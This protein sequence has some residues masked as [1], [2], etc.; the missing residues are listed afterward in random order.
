ML[1]RKGSFTAVAEDFGISVPSVWQQIRA[2]EDA[3]DTSLVRQVGKTTKL[4]EHGEQLVQ[5]AQPLVD[6]FEQIHELFADRIEKLPRRLTVATTASLLLHELQRP[7]AVVRERH[8]DIELTFID[9]PSAIALKHLENGDADIA[10]IGRLAN[11]PAPEPLE[12][13]PLTSYPFMLVCP[14]GHPLAKARSVR[15]ADIIRHPLVLPGEGSNSRRHV[16]QVFDAAGVWRK[17]RIALTA[18]SFDILAGYVRTGFGI[19]VTSVSPI[20]LR[21]AAA[22]HPGYQG[23]LFRDLSRSIGTERVILA[24]R[25]SGIE[26]PHHRSFREI[27]EEFLEPGPA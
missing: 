12:V 6:G 13:T 23:I 18:S 9:R 24:H 20:I 22:G 3:F 1:S 25:R 26:L 11:E 2:L 8:P 15:P 17:A 4:T 21:Q 27:V 14:E 7:L 5:L 16:Q 19:A 10:I